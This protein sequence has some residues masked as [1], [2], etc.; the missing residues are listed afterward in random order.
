MF[1]VKVEVGLHC[2]FP[3]PN[4]AG[5]RPQKLRSNHLWITTDPYAEDTFPEKPPSFLPS[6]FTRLL[7]SLLL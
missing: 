7:C 3:M 4:A 5:N 1:R 2:S 6:A